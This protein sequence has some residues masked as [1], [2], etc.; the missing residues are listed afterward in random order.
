M[1]KTLFNLLA[2]LDE[3]LD[4]GADRQESRQSFKGV[5]MLILGPVKELAFDMILDAD[6]VGDGIHQFR[7]FRS[8]LVPVESLAIF[9][10][11]AFESDTFKCRSGD[12]A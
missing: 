5:W 11:V 8:Y 2:S 9:V 1:F 7:Y 4:F 6:D 10:L 12:L 3:R